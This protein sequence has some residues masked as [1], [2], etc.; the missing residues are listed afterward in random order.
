MV[1][2]HDISTAALG[3]RSDVLPARQGS[4]PP[5]SDDGPHRQLDQLAPAALWGELVLAATTLDG[6]RE[7]ISQVSPASSR[8]LFLVGLDVRG[9]TRDP[10]TSLASPTDRLEPVHLHGVTD[11]SVHLC[12][13]PDLVERALDTGWAEVHQYGDHGTEV[14]V[15]GPRDTDELAVVL[16]LVRASLAWARERN[17]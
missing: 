10:R 1:T 5:T 9:R 16:G 12:L 17:A 2:S 4:R 3:E 8:A 14:M 11:T 6:V 7:G 13:P 15:Y